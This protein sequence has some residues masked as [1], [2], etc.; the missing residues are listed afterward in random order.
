MSQC[1]N[2][3]INVN[4]RLTGLLMNDLEQTLTTLTV[5]QTRMER[6]LSNL[7]S[8]LMMTSVPTS[9][10][11]WSERWKRPSERRSSR[12]KGSY[13][14]KEFTTTLMLYYCR[15]EFQSFLNLSEKVQKFL[16]CHCHIL[17]WK[18]TWECDIFVYCI[19]IFLYSH[20]FSQG[21]DLHT[22]FFW[23]V[24]IVPVQTAQNTAIPLKYIITVTVCMIM[25]LGLW[26]NSSNI[27]FNLIEMNIHTR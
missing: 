18:Y 7:E 20:F 24:A 26:M 22:K 2:K 11:L 23:K 14:C 25:F 4:G 10:K 8:C 1:F 16:T 17:I 6:P 27:V 12:L 21:S 19:G 15:T 9:L 3:Y 5:S 13:Y